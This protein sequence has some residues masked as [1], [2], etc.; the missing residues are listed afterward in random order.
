MRAS[1]VIGAARG[2]G[3]FIEVAGFRQ[4]NIWN[5]LSTKDAK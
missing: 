2:L 1:S 3:F 4:V 5:K